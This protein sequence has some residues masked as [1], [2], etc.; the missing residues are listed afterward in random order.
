MSLTAALRQAQLLPPAEAR[1]LDAGIRS[2]QGEK[3]LENIA[4]R[5]LERSEDQVAGLAGKIEPAVVIF[6]CLLIGLVLLS[7][8]LPLMNIMNTIG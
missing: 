3:A 8:M 6:S 1:L 2:G 5:L 7:V 4:D